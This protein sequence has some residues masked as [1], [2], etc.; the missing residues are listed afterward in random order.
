LRGTSLP[1]RVESLL[2]TLSVGGRTPE[3]T[4]DGSMLGT[5]GYMAPEQAR[6]EI[7]ELDVRADVYALGAILFEV[8]TLTPLH[9][10]GSVDTLVASILAGAEARPSMRAPHRD[11][12][13]EFDAICAKATAAHPDERY[14]SARELCEAVERVLDGDIDRERRRELSVMHA[15]RA[16]EA[17]VRARGGDARE[18]RRAFAEAAR[19]LA[20][21]PD[22]IDAVRTVMRL[23]LEPPKDIPEPVRRAVEES[24]RAQVRAFA[25]IAIPV[26]AAG[27]GLW[28]LLCAMG[29]RSW[30]LHGLTLA[31][32]LGIIGTH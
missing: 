32:L 15:A 10:R 31:M 8:L 26:Y 30:L 17:A 2:R 25:R 5:L 29:V 24:L 21:D 4:V 1:A 16:A 14:E 28:V 6:G 7:A 23:R 20:L 11:V 22:N 12:P 3:G 27:V 9:P 18:R 19:A 13:L